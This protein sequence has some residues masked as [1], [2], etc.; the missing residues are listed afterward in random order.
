LP[1]GQPLAGRQLQRDHHDVGRDLGDRAYARRHLLDR[2]V[3]A[4]GHLAR[5]DDQVAVR[6]GAAKQRQAGRFLVRAQCPLLV[7]AVFD[8]A[9]DDLAFARAAG[10]VFAAVGQTDAG[11]DRRRQ[12]GFIGIAVELVAA[13]QYGNLK[14]HEWQWW[15]TSRWRPS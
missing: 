10:A 14:G 3:A 11:A 9:A 1:V 12:D 2:I 4:A 8:G 13:G 6:G 5:F 15:G 7:R